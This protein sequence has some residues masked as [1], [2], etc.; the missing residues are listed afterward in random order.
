MMT[1][2][3]V[4]DV[5]DVNV[6]WIRRPCFVVCVYCDVLTLLYDFDT[7]CVSMFQ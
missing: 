1:D 5:V 7:H 3:V 4:D 2:D 6:C